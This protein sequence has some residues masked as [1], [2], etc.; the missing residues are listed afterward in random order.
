MFVTDAVSSRNAKPVPKERLLAFQEP[1]AKRTFPVTVTRDVGMLGMACDLEF[2]VGDTKVAIFDQGETATFYVEPA[3]VTF[4]ANLDQQAKGG[5]CY[6]G[7]RPVYIQLEAAR[8]DRT[9]AS[10]RLG[11]LIDRPMIKLGN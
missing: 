6:W 5:Y 10:L 7:S 4:E 1:S 3:L 8:Q 9:K 11:I 2:W